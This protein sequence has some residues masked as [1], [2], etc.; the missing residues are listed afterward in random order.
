MLATAPQIASTVVPNT[1][2][3]QQSSEKLGE[4]V[5]LWEI[6]SNVETVSTGQVLAFCYT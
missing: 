4:N 2:E 3:T 6:V 1:K 5:M